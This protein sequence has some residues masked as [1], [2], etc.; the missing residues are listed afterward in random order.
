MRNLL[1][2]NGKA[3]GAQ[4]RHLF[5]TLARLPIIQAQREVSHTALGGFRTKGRYSK[6]TSTPL[7]GVGEGS[8]G[9]DGKT[10]LI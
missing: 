4:G 9:S 7:A 10:V 3:V 8:G 5:N 6:T 2:E 1:F